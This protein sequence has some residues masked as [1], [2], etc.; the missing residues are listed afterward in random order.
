MP[1]EDISSSTQESE[2]GQAADTASL[3]KGSRDVVTL[4]NRQPVRM[5][6]KSDYVL[7]D[8]FDFYSFDLSKPKGDIVIKLNGS[9]CDYMSPVH[10]GDVVDIYWEG[11]K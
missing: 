11:L 5:T 10:D 3:K 1:G 4:V 6:G 2:S 8:L 9:T 7:V